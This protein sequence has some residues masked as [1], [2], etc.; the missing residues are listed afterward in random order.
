M[1]RDATKGPT[2]LAAPS[3]VRRADRAPIGLRV[4][5]RYRVLGEIGAGAFGKVCL[6]EDE[7][8]GLQIAIRFLPC[9]LAGVL[10]G[11]QTSQRTV[12]SIVAT[13]TAH[14]ALVHVL[15]L[16]E[17]DNGQ[18]FGAMELVE[19]RRLSEVLSAG[20]F[21]V[22]AALRAAIDFGGAVEALHNMGLIHGAVRPRNVMVLEDGRAKLWGVEW[23]GLR[24]GT[25]ALSPNQWGPGSL[26]PG[27]FRGAPVTEKTDFY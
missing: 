14:P 6:A 26:S 9:E 5:D 21:E 20:P 11:A 25:Q 15:E 17:A 16:G 27:E 7:G 18:A 3:S 8:T 12:R 4:K 24:S 10:R 19:G 13:W 1:D 22:A 23:P 2:R